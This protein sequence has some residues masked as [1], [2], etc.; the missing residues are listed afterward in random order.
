MLAPFIGPEEFADSWAPLF[1]PGAL[2]SLAACLCGRSQHW[3][4]QGRFG[5]LAAT[6]ATP[7]G[8]ESYEHGGATSLAWK[9]MQ[10]LNRDGLGVRVRAH[11]AAGHCTHQ[12]LLREFRPGLTQGLSLF[13]LVVG[14]TT[15][16]T[17]PLRN[18]WQAIVKG[19]LAE[20]WLLGCKAVSEEIKEGL[21][22]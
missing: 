15:E 12:A 3:Y 17:I 1:A 10:A 18:R 4:L 7:W 9:L 19:K 11:C 6:Y 8:Q 5:K 16:W 13:R 14:P 22:R 20:R 2:V 21:E